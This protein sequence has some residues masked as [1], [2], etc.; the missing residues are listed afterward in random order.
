MRTIVWLRH[1]LPQP[2]ETGVFEP[3][4]TRFFPDLGGGDLRGEH[5]DFDRSSIGQRRGMEN[6]T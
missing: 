1:R 6:G 5:P 4:K 3:S 2:V